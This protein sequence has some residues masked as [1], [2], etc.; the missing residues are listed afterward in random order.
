MPMLKVGHNVHWRGAFGND[1]PQ[2]ARVESIKVTNGEKYDKPVNEI[3]WDDVEG[4]NVVVTL[5]NGFWAYGHQIYKIPYEAR[6]VIDL[7][8]RKED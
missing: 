7:C 6:V 8:M 4:R 5:G 1:E 3:D 2:I